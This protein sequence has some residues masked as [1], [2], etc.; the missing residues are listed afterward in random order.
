MTPLPGVFTGRKFRL[1][2]V[3]RKRHLLMAAEAKPVSRRGTK[4]TVTIAKDASG[5]YGVGVV[6]TRVGSA[7][8][9]FLQG[10]AEE[11]GLLQKRLGAPHARS[12]V[13]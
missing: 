1:P 12:V 5:S 13:S 9:D 6:Q 8:V 4:H 2:R 10:A 7:Q 11:A 3:L